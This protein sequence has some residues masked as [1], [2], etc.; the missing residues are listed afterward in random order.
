MGLS[1][2]DEKFKGRVEEGINDDFM[3]GAVRSARNGCK[4]TGWQRPMNSETG[5]NGV[6]S[7]K[8]SASMF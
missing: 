1:I 3:R 4:P 6:R 8:K 5:K 7:A 2:S